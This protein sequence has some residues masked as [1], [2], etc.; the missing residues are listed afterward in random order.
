MTSRAVPQPKGPYSTTYRVGEMLYLSGQGSIDPSSGEVIPGDIGQ[1]TRNTLANVEALL[2]A[3]GFTVEDLAQ[4]TCYLTD[5]DQ[6]QAMNEAYSEYLG[7]R[8]RAVRTAV[9]VSRLPFG[10][11]LEMTCIAHRRT[12][13]DL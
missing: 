9:E 13:D 6:W 12:G 2:H 7:A 3:H 1:Q 11:A 10:L 8:A 4:V 5:I